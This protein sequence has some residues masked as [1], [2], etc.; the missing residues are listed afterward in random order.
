[1]AGKQ[2]LTALMISVLPLVVLVG[3]PSTLDWQNIREISNDQAEFDDIIALPPEQLSSL[4]IRPASVAWIRFTVT[5]EKAGLYV[6]SLTAADEIDLYLQE[7]PER[8]ATSA[9]NFRH[10]AGGNHRRLAGEVRRPN[11]FLVELNKGKASYTGYIR[12]KTNFI[13]RLYQ[14]HLSLVSVDQFNN[15][16]AL[17]RNLQL[18]FVVLFFFI[19][20][21]HLSLFIIT[22]FKAYL[23]HAAYC[24]L[25][26]V[27]RFFSYYLP[28]DLGITSYAYQ[29]GFIHIL[30]TLFV[31]LSVL[32]GQHLLDTQQNYPKWHKMLNAI[33]YGTIAMV[34]LVAGAEFYFKSHLIAADFYL[35]IVHVPAI[36]CITTFSITLLPK[37]NAV[38]RCFML[39][40]TWLYGIMFI[41]ALSI[42]N[43]NNQFASILFYL[44]FIGEV[45]LFALGIGFRMREIEK[46]RQ[47]AQAQLIDQYRVN[48]ALN[49]KVTLELEQRVRERT[50]EIELQKKMIEEKNNEILTQNEELQAQSEELLAQ[51]DVLNEKSMVIEQQNHE[52][53]Q[54]NNSLEVK[55]EDRSR[56]LRRSNDQL[57]K[58]NRELQTAIDEIQDKKE[59]ITEFAYLTAHHLRGPVARAKGLT[60][61]VKYELLQPPEIPFVIEKIDQSLND[62]DEVIHDMNQI[63]DLHAIPANDWKSENI[64]AMLTECLNEFRYSNGNDTIKLS[65]DDSIEIFTVKA[66]FI[67]IFA[68]LMTNAMK[69]KK[70][71]A[72]L[73]LEIVATREN[74]KAKIAV[75]DFGRGIDLMRFE[76]KL[77]KLYQRFHFD[78]EGKGVGLYLVKQLTRM[79]K[80]DIVVDSE[81]G[82]YTTFTLFF[83]SGSDVQP[84]DTSQ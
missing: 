17:S 62:A 14:P 35:P 76:S 38:T 44:A 32:F 56:E 7:N 33:K 84:L 69:F 12:L 22:Q 29:S 79:L 58:A 6:L 11:S 26:S 53:Q 13:S 42:I 43:A 30:S 5:P 81:P 20:L 67:A 37:K 16:G 47:L 82:Q 3:Q 31:P 41:A 63:L 24:L 8:S 40:N 54:L 78:I 1:M 51:R 34:L 15:S 59:Q 28:E 72:P 4:P 73:T 60:H 65:G 23:L 66:H 80:A 21:Y 57:T 77:F 52:L 83:T 39:G 48:E 70:I 46:N 10:I 9:K 19:F 71:G 68:E 49:A 2:F 45:L 75:R 25:V 27:F 55:V 18:S 64:K 74:E 36:V 61:L 50:A